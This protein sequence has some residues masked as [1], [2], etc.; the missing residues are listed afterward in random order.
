MLSQLA[1]SPL[2]SGTKTVH[3]V[4]GPSFYDYPADGQQGQQQQMPPQH[5]QQNV[6]AGAAGPISIQ[7]IAIP[8]ICAGCVIG[9]GGT[10]IRDLRSQSGTNI[11]IADP[12]PVTPDERVV[13]ITGTPVGIQTA[14]YL[15][16]QCVESYVPPS[17]QGGDEQQQE[18][19]QQ[20]QEQQQQ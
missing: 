18:E 9:R 14:V 2:R 6:P 15:I 17:H 8:T 3:F 10:I 1:E 12:D 19:Q 5:A 20:E 11:S 4:P 7:K 13:T 16:R